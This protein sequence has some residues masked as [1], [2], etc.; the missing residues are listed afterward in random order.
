MIDASK[1]RRVNR[2][3]WNASVRFSITLYRIGMES[4]HHPDHDWQ[5]RFGKLAIR[6][7]LRHRADYAFLDFELG[8][9]PES[10]YEKNERGCEYDTKTVEHG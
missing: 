4:P 10:Y 7:G 8:G 6:D 3:F 9:P 2:Q 1:S 5:K